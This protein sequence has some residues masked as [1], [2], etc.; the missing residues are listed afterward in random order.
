[1]VYFYLPWLGRRKQQLGKTGTWSPES[2]ILA[3]VSMSG[4]CWQG[5]QQQWYGDSWGCQG[6][7]RPQTV[8]LDVPGSLWSPW[9]EWRT[10]VTSQPLSLLGPST[11]GWLFLRFA[12]PSTPLVP[13]LSA[14][15]PFILCI[16]F[17][18]PMSLQNRHQTYPYRTSPWC[19]PDTI[20]TLGLVSLHTFSECKG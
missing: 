15:S 7:L 13:F 8:W 5:P 9:L 3:A 2:H 4:K 20:T 14:S 11:S 16:S 19:F 6:K 12:H 10:R 17:L 1:M 18:L